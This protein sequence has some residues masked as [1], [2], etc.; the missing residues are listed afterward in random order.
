MKSEYLQ[1][2]KSLLIYSLVLLVFTIPVWIFLP[3]VYITPALP[4]LF[5]FFAATCLLSYY[6]L[7][8]TLNERLLKFVNT[9]MLLT[10]IKLVLYVSVMIVYVLLNLADAVPFM[11]SFFVL[12]LAYTIF[13]V[14]H[15]ISASGKKRP[16]T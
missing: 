3:K 1:F 14:V 11:L 4:F 12:Y 6:Y 15:V 13:E 2:L 10:L 5:F 7:L 16:A 8:K 9:F